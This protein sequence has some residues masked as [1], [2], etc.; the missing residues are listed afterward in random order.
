MLSLNAENL[1]NSL[2]EM[3]PEETEVLERKQRLILIA[4]MRQMKQTAQNN[5]Y[6]AAEAEQRKRLTTVFEETQEI[7]A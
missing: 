2:I 1:D 6:K 5:L 4:K 7:T 3:D